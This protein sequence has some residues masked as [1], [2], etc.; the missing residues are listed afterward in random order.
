MKL[1]LILSEQ[2][3]KSQGRVEEVNKQKKTKKKRR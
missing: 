3:D 1:W 2:N